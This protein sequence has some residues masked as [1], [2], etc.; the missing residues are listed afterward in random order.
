[1]ALSFIAGSLAFASPASAAT[2]TQVDSPASA[3]TLTQVDNFG[4]NPTNLQMYEYV[5]AKLP[6]HPAVLVAAHWCTGSGP[7][8]FKYT[9]FASLADQYGF[10]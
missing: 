10:I 2:L 5:P 3:P 6:R 1:M 7:D 8:F 4:Y 9:D